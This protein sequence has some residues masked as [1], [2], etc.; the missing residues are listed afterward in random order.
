V[1]VAGQVNFEHV[2]S[3][4]VLEAIEDFAAVIKDLPFPDEI[5][6]GYGVIMVW[7]HIHRLKQMKEVLDNKPWEADWGK[8]KKNI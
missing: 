2:G 4:A 5:A 7:P 3:K 8:E 6:P 1:T